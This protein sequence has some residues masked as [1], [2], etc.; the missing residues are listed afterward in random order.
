MGT[1]RWRPGPRA[2]PMRAPADGGSDVLHG[3]VATP[4]TARMPAPRLVES[5]YPFTGSAGQLSFAS[6]ALIEV[7]A[8]G[9]P[10]GWWEGRH[11]G[12][13]GFFPAT[14]IKERDHA[15][16]KPAREAATLASRNA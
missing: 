4:Y 12:V 6:G 10:G 11:E 8:E 9:E 2:R 13:T 15:E 16:A 1:S 5:V 7:V 14:Y 3:R